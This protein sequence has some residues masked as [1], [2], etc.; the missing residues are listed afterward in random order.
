VAGETNQEKQIR[1]YRDNE[2]N[3]F[4]TSKHYKLLILRN[5]RN[6]EIA[7]NMVTRSY[8]RI[9]GKSI[10]NCDAR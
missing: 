4:R 3:F 5:A 7:I 9:L 1:S 10:S 6:T 8:Q 2:L